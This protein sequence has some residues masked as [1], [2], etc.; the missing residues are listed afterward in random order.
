[1]NEIVTKQDF[2]NTVA[3]IE[4]EMLKL[5]N[6]VV[7][8]RPEMP[9]THSFGDGTYVRDLFIPKGYLVVGK[10]HK[11][12]TVNILLKGE[13]TILAEGGI[14]RLKAPAYFI[15]EANSKK[16][17]YAHEDTTWLNVFPN[18]T[19]EREI[20]KIEKDVAL[21]DYADENKNIIDVDAKLLVELME[22]ENVRQAEI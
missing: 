21:E 18:P 2:R 14:K 3:N 4:Q 15:G 8:D 9:V 11:R 7:G 1:M 20:E 12:R 16:V 10:I 6:T 22:K 5:P 17:G 13:I 19:D